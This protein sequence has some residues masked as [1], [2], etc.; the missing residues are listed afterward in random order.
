MLKVAMKWKPFFM[1]LGLLVANGISSTAQ[2]III[3]DPTANKGKVEWQWRIEVGKTTFDNPITGKFVIKNISNQPLILK[4]VE[5]GCHCTVTE[6]TQ[7][8]ILPNQYG[9]IKATFDAKKVGRFYKNVFVTTNFDEKQMV[10]LAMEGE[11]T[12][13]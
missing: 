4:S 6:Y 9:T 8:P 13:Q 12:A 2:N 10:T 11:V 1:V 3:E 5:S 7:D